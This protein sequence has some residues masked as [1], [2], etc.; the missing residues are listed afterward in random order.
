MGVHKK[1]HAGAGQHPSQSHVG[2]HPPGTTSL[3][4]SSLNNTTQSSNARQTAKKAIKTIPV[5]S[6]HSLNRIQQKQYQQPVDPQI[7]PEIRTQQI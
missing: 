6:P 1:M 2:M 4:Q 5:R 7:L 3:N